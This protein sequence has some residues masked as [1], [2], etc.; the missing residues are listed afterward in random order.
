MRTGTFSGFFLLFTVLA[1]LCGARAE[2]AVLRNGQ[3]L[4]ITGYE[5]AGATMRL[6][7]E[8]GTVSVPAENVIGIEPEEIFPALPPP[9]KHTPFGDLIRAAAE[10]HGV[11]ERLVS[12][13]I[14]AE[15]KFNP[16]AVSRK[17]ARGLMQL[18]PGTATRFAVQNLFDPAQNIEGGT[19]YLKELLERY[20]QDPRLVLAA[21]NA[22]PERVGRY[23]GVPPFP[24][25]QAYVRQVLRNWQGRK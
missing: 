5:H 23:R 4:H 21:Y 15:S 1:P 9:P 20:H 16:W 24:E 19:R 2:Y 12:S 14:A 25:T 10:R 18:M 13:L 3:R 11:D 8:G 17:Q 6:H 22:G 7:V